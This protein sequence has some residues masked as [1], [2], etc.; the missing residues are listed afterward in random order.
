MTVLRAALVQ[1]TDRARAMLDFRSVYEANV[2]AIWRFLQ[3]LGVPERHLEDA[4]Q[5]TFIIAHRQLASFRGASS[6]KTWLHGIAVRVAKDYRRREARKGGWEPLSQGLLDE[7]RSPHEAAEDQQALRQ[8]LQVLEEL[9]EPQRAVFVLVELE[10]LTAP[11]VAEVLETNVN[12]VSTRLRAAR[13]RFNARIE[14][15]GGLP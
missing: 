3:R 15:L 2:G 7:R 13:Q 6:L 9:A 5:D 12:T 1:E 8:V 11:E 10:G 4:T 14:A